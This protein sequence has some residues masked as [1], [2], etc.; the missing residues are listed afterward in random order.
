[1]QNLWRCHC[2]RVVHL[3]KTRSRVHVLT[4]LCS[5]C[6]G[7]TEISLDYQLPTCPRVFNIFHPYDP[8]VRLTSRLMTYKDHFAGCGQSRSQISL[9][10]KWEHGG[11][12]YSPK[13]FSCSVRIT[14]W[15]WKSWI[16]VSEI[17]LGSAIIFPCCQ[18]LF[19]TE[20][21]VSFRLINSFFL[22]GMLRKLL[23]W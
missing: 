14:N 12:K 18:C 20:N 15:E 19:L 9:S 3:M 2:R 13:A 23:Q 4:S 8:V 22:Q 6:R 16:G 11:E 7:A 21:C 5:P 1:M 10:R 17:I